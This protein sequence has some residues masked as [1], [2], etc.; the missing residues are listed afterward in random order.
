ME[1]TLSRPAGRRAAL[2]GIASL[3]VAV[4]SPSALAQAP[5]WP[6]RP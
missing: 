2:A 4:A 1:T 3:L 6:T 5:S